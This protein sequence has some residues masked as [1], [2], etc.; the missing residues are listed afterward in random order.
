MLMIICHHAAM[1]GEYPA[2]EP[3]AVNGYFV[4][5][6]SIGGKIGVNIFI[7]ISGYF[8]AESKF[9]ITKALKTVAQA[10]FYSTALSL[11]FLIIGRV[12][13]SASWLLSALLPISSNVWWFLSVYFILYC[14]SPFLNVL[15]KNCGRKP[16]VILIA[17]LT[18]IQCLVPYVGT[19]YLSNVAWFITLYLIAAYVRLYPNKIFDSNKIALPIAAALL[20]AIALFKVFLNVDL[21]EM[22][23]I[24]CLTSSVAIFCAFKNFKIKNS[25][26]INAVART[27]FG[28]YLIHDYAPMR[29]LLWVDL[30][31]C[32]M[33]YQTDYY[34][35]FVIVAVIVVFAACMAIDFVRELLFRAAAMLIS[36]IKRK[37]SQKKGVG[38]NL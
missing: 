10:I 35:P 8:M 16:L 27:T 11:L 12:E 15:I 29:R 4:R 37:T 7:L 19:T 5:L 23:N 30:L 32:P 26:I 14:L 24:V 6:F 36:K 38:T 25:K 34:V 2:T 33:H 22:T 20:V 9:R 21:W 28:I 1:H 18:V 17:F 31:N 13:F 3:L